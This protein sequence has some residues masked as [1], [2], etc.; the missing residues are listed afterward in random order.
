MK[1]VFLWDFITDSLINKK[2]QQNQKQKNQLIAYL[3]Y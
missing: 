1:L 2:P 3:L